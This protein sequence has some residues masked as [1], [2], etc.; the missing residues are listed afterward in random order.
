M[1]IVDENFVPDSNVVQ[2]PVVTSLNLDPDL[3]LSGAMGTL[4]SAIVIGYDKEG[5]EYFA[6]SISNGPEVLWLLE[7][8]KKLLLEVEG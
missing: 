2:L 5:F 6:S 4:E 3:V 7:R 8:L 1:K